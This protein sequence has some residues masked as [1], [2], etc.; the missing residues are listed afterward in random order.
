MNYYLKDGS[1]FARLYELDCSDDTVDDPASDLMLWQNICNSPEVTGYRTSFRLPVSEDTLSICNISYSKLDD[2]GVYDYYST[3][4]STEQ[5]LELYYDCMLPDIA[6]GRL[7]GFW[8]VENGEYFNVKTNADIYIELVDRDNMED[9]SKDKYES[10]QFAVQTNSERCLKWIE[11]NTDIVPLP[12]SE[13][14]PRG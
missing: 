12:M 7:A 14:E 13:V 1:H 6:D 3:K 10:I 4:L 2:D 8:A 9:E 11:E 5:A